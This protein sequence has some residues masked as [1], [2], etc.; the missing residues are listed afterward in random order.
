VPEALDLEPARQRPLDPLEGGAVRLDGHDPRPA[1]AQR[2]RHG[3]AVGPQKI[4]DVGPPE[5]QVPAG[6]SPPADLPPV[7]PVVDRLQIDVAE[8]S[9]LR[10]GEEPAGGSARSAHAGSSGR[11]RPSRQTYRE[12]PGTRTSRTSCSGSPGNTMAIAPS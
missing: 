7:G 6:R 8:G 3:E 10:R 12:G 4:D 11:K 9:D 1:L 5:A 2:A